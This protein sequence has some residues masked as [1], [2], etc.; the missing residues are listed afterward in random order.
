MPKGWGNAPENSTEEPGAP[1]LFSELDFG[2]LAPFIEK[3]TTQSDGICKL[4][5]ELFS[6]ETKKILTTPGL[7]DTQVVSSL[8]EALNGIICKG[9][10]KSAAGAG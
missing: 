7:N 8:V 10:L 3:L 4:L 9:R 1:I 2:C 6:D 5:W